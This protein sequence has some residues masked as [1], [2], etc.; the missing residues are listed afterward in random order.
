MDSRRKRA[1]EARQKILQSGNKELIDR[2]H[3]LEATQGNPQIAARGRRG[4][5]GLL[6]TGLAA[7]GG[8]YLGTLFAGMVMS[9]QMQQAFADV[10]MDLGVSPLDIGLD[11]AHLD[12]DPGEMGA[13][14]GGFLDGFG[15]D[16]FDI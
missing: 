4:G 8:A 9:S 16:F 3:F 2:L 11:T 15:D 7:A 5:P 10:A 14:E 12:L 13:D 1:E 6:G